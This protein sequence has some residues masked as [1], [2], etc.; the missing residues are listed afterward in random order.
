MAKTVTCLFGSDSQA[1]SI[2]RELEQSGISQGKICLFTASATTVPGTA[3]A[4]STRAPADRIT[5][6]LRIT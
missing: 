6:A 1:S 5:T 4:A 2:V 3:P